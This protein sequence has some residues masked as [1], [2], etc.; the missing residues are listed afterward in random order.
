M[1]ETGESLET[2]DQRQCKLDDALASVARGVPSSWRVVRLK[3]SE[4]D[5]FV[6]EPSDVVLAVGQDGL[7]ANV[8]KYLT[9]QFVIGFNPDPQI[10]EGVLVRNNPADAARLVIATGSGAIAF[11]DRTMVQATLEDGQQLLALNEIFIGHRSHQS[12]RYQLRVGQRAEHQSSSGLIVSTGTG[13]TGWARSINAERRSS[14]QLPKPMDSELALFV[15]EAFPGS[16]FQATLTETVVHRDES[17][18]VTSEMDDAGVI[19]GDGIED[20]RIPFGFGAQASISVA[21][22]RLR[23]VVDASVSATSAAA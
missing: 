5:R 6:F 8:A 10:Y 1:K 19:F 2:Y 16:G 11:E 23:L 4:L 3:R 13:S 17:V 9:G 15:R 21:A 14:V 20:D 7:V 12:A 18:V 22:N